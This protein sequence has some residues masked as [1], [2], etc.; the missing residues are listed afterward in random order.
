[1]MDCFLE[2]MRKH[3]LPLTREKYLKLAYFGNPPEE[4][5]A[6]EESMLPEQ[7]PERSDDDEG[8]V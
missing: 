3:N 1:M 7:F 5:S 4:L 2:Y 6:E 8:N